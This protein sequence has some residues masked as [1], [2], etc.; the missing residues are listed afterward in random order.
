MNTHNAALLLLK[1]SER[2]SAFEGL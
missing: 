2:I 1:D